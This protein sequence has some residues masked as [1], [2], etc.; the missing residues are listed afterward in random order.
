MLDLRRLRLLHSLAAHG[1]V[2]AAAKALHLTG[3][4]VSQQIATLERE[5]GVS[6]VRRNGRRLTLTDA[7]HVLVAHAAVLLDQLAA[8][9]ADLLALRTQIVGTVRLA[10][11]ASATAT[12]VG[13]AWR[14]IVAEHGDR[15]TLRLT[16]ME[17][18]ESLPALTRG[19]IDLAVTHSYDLLPFA[20]PPTSE[21]H[22]LLTDPVVVALPADDPACQEPSA[23][24][25]CL[26]DHP[27]LSVASDTS[28]HQMLQRA[29]GIAGF[30]PHLV[31]Q[32]NDY[33]AILSLV[34]AGAGVTLLPTLGARHLPPNVVLRPLRQPINRHV[35]AITRHQGDRHPAISVILEHLITAAARC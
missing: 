15:L 14:S 3:P 32:T 34:S 12:F 25:S 10:S 31:A 5:A 11:F 21:R 17:P 13:D 24:L 2:S 7:G 18:E 16:G 1:T 20:L 8:A 27:W 19:E 29:C 33:A 26:S 23:D 6:L 35:F 28:C 9:E 22:D 4:A 30:V